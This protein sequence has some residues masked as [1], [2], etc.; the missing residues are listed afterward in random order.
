[1][2]SEARAATFIA[3]ASASSRTQDTQGPNDVKTV[4]GGSGVTTGAG[5]LTDRTFEEGAQSASSASATAGVG[6]VHGFST[7]GAASSGCCSTARGSSAAFASYADSFV[8]SSSTIAPGT[9]GVLSFDILAEGIADGGGSGAGWAGVSYWVARAIVNGTLYQTSFEHRANGALGVTDTGD[10]FGLYTF[11]ANVVFGQTVNVQ[12]LIDT[13]ATAQVAPGGSVAQFTADLSDTVSWEGIRSLAVGGVGVT[14][15]TAV[16]RDTGFDFATG[17]GAAAAGGGGVP[18][19]ST[20]ALMLLGF[21]GLGAMLRRKRFA[22]AKGYPRRFGLQMWGPRLRSSVEE[23]PVRAI[24]P[25]DCAARFL[26]APLAGAFLACAASASAAPL[27]SF[28]DT[29]PNAGG[30]FAFLSDLRVN[31][32]ASW[33]QTVASSDVSVRVFVGSLEG[34]TTPANWWITTSLGSDTTQANVIASGV[35]NPID[36]SQGAP[37]DLNAIPRIELASGLSFAPG[38]YYIV[39]D[40]PAGPAQENAAWFGGVLSGFAADTL[41]L[42]DGFSLGR[43]YSATT[44]NFDELPPL[45]PFGP[46]SHFTQNEPSRFFLAFE[47]DSAAVPEPATWAL[48]I[49][50]FGLAGAALRRRGMSVVRSRPRSPGES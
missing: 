50:G 34:I 24:R 32:A 37:R 10:D 29:T 26:F 13:G 21:A 28:T 3:S 22:G 19:P 33:T 1:M 40:G 4:S 17:Y 44:G 14:D 38:T 43:T 16:S 30:S 11:T 15:F 35:Y 7:A 45:N 9:L 42:A 18:E 2:T 8:L 47:L 25:G 31:Q 23:P 12:L 36:S 39:L 20:W 49:A 48:M 27:L 46:A 5:S 41:N 6:A